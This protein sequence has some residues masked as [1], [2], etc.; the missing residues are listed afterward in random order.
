MPTIERNLALWNAEYDWRD[1]GEEWSQA[2]GGSAMLWERSLLPRLRRFLP[3]EGTL[4][5][6]APGFGRWSGY[7]L[8]H[9][10]ALHLIDLAPK[11][12]AACRER[13]KASARVSYAVNDGRSLPGVPAGAVDFVFSFDS[14]V[15]AGLDALSGYAAELRRVLAPDGVA[16]LHHS[17]AGEHRVYYQAMS[18][19]PSGVRRRLAGVLDFQH[20]RALDVT[21]AAAR[22]ELERAGLVV[23]LQERINW[24]TKRC[25]DC[26]TFACLPGSRHARPTVIVENPHFMGEADSA[27]AGAPAYGAAFTAAR[28]TR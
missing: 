8:A 9:A 15:H 27:R 24:G 2:W 7:L 23:F 22:A 1:A 6:I 21:A 12:I 20:G 18:A 19:L 4:V 17:T 13:F 14:L 16:F 11:C 5:E 10:R 26:L 25:I 28:R 3:E